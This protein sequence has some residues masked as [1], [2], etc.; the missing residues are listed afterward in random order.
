MIINGKKY[1][2]PT[3]DEERIIEQ[4]KKEWESEIDRIP[5]SDLQSWP[6]NEN[7]SNRLYREATNKYTSKIIALLENRSK[8]ANVG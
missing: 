1:R 3:H 8:I 7:E 6:N 5:P 4:Y 2:D